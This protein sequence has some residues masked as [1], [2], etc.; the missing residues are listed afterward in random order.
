MTQVKVMPWVTY[1][2]QFKIAHAKAITKQKG[3]KNIFG[4]QRMPRQV[5]LAAAAENKRLRAEGVLP[6]KDAVALAK[7]RKINRNHRGRVSRRKVTLTK[8]K[9]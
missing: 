4:Y 1:K 3:I 9:F 2:R 6:Q 5:M 7:L 8:I